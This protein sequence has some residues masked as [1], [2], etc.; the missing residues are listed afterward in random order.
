MSV[1][2]PASE[3]RSLPH[4]D[5]HEAV[6]ATSVDSAWQA[7]L[8]GLESSLSGPGARSIARALG[9]L[10]VGAGEPRP[11]APGSA[12]SGFHVAAAEEPN[13]LALAGWHRFSRYALIFRLEQVDAR[14]TRLRAESRAEFPGLH[15][16]VYRAL[17]IGTG[18]HVLAVRRLLAGIQRDATAEAR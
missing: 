9:C 12:L 1:L 15:G 13:L 7:L 18:G 10:D 17:V 4:I 8:E 3:F 11:P 2:T 16:Q 6:L 14:R 5:E